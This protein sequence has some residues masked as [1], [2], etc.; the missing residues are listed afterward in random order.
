MVGEQLAEW[1][2]EQSISCA[3]LPPTALSVTSPNNLPDLKTLVSAGESCTPS[4]VQ[5][6]G[7]GR[8]LI[9]AYGPTEV[10]VCAT[11][12]LCAPGASVVSIGRPIRNA[13]VYVLDGRGEPVPV[14]VAGELYVGGAGVSRG[15]LGRP[16]LTAE[17]FV[18]DPFSS[19]PGARL[20]RTGDVAR[21]LATGELEYVG[22]V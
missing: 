6:W 13:R 9:N 18:P 3:I 5:T 14:G 17:R 21:W 16:A 4:I 19:E 22:R 10:T 20:Y 1:L 2:R 8:R 11:Q 7:T 12:G 15:Y